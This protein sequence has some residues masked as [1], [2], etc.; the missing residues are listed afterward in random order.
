MIAASLR[1]AAGDIRARLASPAFPA[2]RAGRIV[3]CEGLLLQVEGLEAAVGA[4]V[5]I[6]L[7]D[8]LALAEAEVIGFRAGRLLLMALGPAPVAPGAAAWLRGRADRVRVGP[9]LFGRISSASGEPLDGKAAWRTTADWPLAG[10]PLPALDR[11]EVR[12]PLETGVRAIDTLLTL[13]RGQRVGLI[14]GSGVGKSVL[15][16]QLARGARSDAVV[17]ALIGE[18]GREIGSFIAQLSPEALARSHVV[19][20]PADAAAPLRIRGALSAFAIAEWLRAQGQH[21]LLIVDSLTRIAHAQRE[22]GLAAGEPPGR[23]GYPPSALDMIPCL[24]ERAGNDRAGGG[25]I[26]ALMTVLADGDDL[27]SDPVVDTARGVLDGHILLDR[28]IAG[29]GRFP[30]IDLGNSLSRTMAD[31]VPPEHLAAAARFRRDMA[32]VEANRDLVAMGAYARGHDLALDRALDGAAVMESFLAQAQ[33]ERH[34][35]ADSRA[36][37]LAGWNT[38]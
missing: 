33:P 19:A 20:V 37:L 38:D 18:R 13:G 25:A 16:Q 6:E 15:I 27:V 34:A 24:V 29:R 5:E 22:I 1:A 23:R 30:A 10:Q 35:M 2:A 3:A 7:G 11:A 14:A 36:A 4:R 8:G 26:T 9:A 12:E 31:C 21:V 28:S 17:I 32:L